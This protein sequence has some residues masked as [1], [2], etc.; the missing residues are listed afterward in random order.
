MFIWV[1]FYVIGGLSVFHA[2]NLKRNPGMSKEVVNMVIYR[3][4]LYIGMFIIC[5][6]YVFLNRVLYLHFFI[7]SKEEDKVIDVSTISTLDWSDPFKYILLVLEFL[8]YS[9]GIWIPLS[10]CAEPYFFLVVLRNFKSFIR[11]ITCRFNKK[12]QTER[13]E[14][15]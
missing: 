4:V 1:L 9:Q 8:F 6:L 12:D 5:N 13:L 10:R 14:E 7:T 15:T 3:H 11:I 2:L